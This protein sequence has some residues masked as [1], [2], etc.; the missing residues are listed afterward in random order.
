MKRHIHSV[1]RGARS[2]KVRLSCGHERSV[3]GH[4]FSD[5]S[6]PVRGMDYDCQEGTCFGREVRA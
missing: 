3:G 1:T 4:R 5:G 2:T 6:V